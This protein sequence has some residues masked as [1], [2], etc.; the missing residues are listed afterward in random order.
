MKI[1]NH[2][3]AIAL[4]S[5][6]F[7]Q[8]SLAEERAIRPTEQNLEASKQALVIGNSAYTHTSPLQNPVNDAQ[9][10]SKT[11][12][13]LGFSVTTLLDTDQRAME[14]TIA[15]FGSS[16]RK[17]DGVGLFYYAGHG[18]QVDGENYL[19]PIDINPKS[20]ADI[21]YDAVP[22]GKLLGQM[23]AAGNSMNLVILDACRNNPFTR[24]FRASSQGLAQVIAPAGSFISYATAPG[25]VAADGEGGN[26][27]FTSKL[28]NHMITPG[29]KLE[30]VFKQVRIDVQKESNNQQVPW[31]SS[32]LTGDFY[33]VPAIAGPP[34]SSQTKL[35]DLQGQANALEKIRLEQQNIQDQW[36]KWQSLML[37]DFQQVTNFGDQPVSAALKIEALDRF[38]SNW[39]E[40]N[41][42]SEQDSVLRLDVQSRRS[43][44]QRI[45]DQDSEFEK[46]AG[47]LKKGDLDSAGKLLRSIQAHYGDSLESF[48]VKQPSVVQYN[49]AKIY[50]KGI[51]V[52][53]NEQIAFNWFRKAAEGGYSK[54]QTMTGYLYQIGGGT[55]KSFDKAVD[56][57]RRASDQG[58]SMAL[59]NL[60]SL[61]LSGNGVL[62]D[63][64]KARQLYQ[65]ASEKGNQ[66]AIQALKRLEK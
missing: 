48:F 63:K 60:G 49:L 29:L 18:M 37:Q 41:P 26:G 11:L 51:R 56:W 53:Q 45:L 8:F 23:E 64:D 21:R 61:Y 34:K 13:Q 30:E 28:L 50:R 35:E 25:Q 32:S 15:M 36:R 2:T 14:A 19:L 66:Q 20:E 7:S 55:H 4:L 38:L 17:F 57:Y 42:F 5:L 33:F 47:M 31:D 6:F 52:S 43:N 46:I 65:Q 24:S 27:L 40:D 59:F 62:K 44:L 1:Q 12:R 16:L 22:V 54:A 3:I 10:V 9:A 39:K 58:E